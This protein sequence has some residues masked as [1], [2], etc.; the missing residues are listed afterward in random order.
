MHK[1]LCVS[2]TDR[3]SDVI[4]V[5]NKISKT[6]ICLAVHQSKGEENFPDKY[7]MTNKLETM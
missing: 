4:K 1:K 5:Y 7:Y 6:N 3:T 2:D